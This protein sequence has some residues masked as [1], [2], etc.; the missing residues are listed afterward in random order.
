[1]AAPCPD[2]G[3][4]PASLSP[5]DAVVALRSFARRFT[6]IG[7]PDPDDDGGAEGD[8]PAEKT[9]A[10]AAA[11]AAAIATSGEQLRRVLVGD[12]PELGPAPDLAAAPAT[13]PADAIDRLRTAA[14][15]VA[16]LAARQP[17]SAWTRTGRRAGQDVTAADLLREAVHAGAHELR[18]AGEGS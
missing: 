1:M 8:A 18:V 6:E 16:D 14:E 2:C 4:D 3:F 9:L 10:A 11:G 7:E 5:P 15:R 17:A 12:S 13:P